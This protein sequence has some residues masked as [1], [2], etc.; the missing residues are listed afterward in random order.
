MLFGGTLDELPDE[1]RAASPLTYVDAVRSPVLITAGAN[2]PRCPPRATDTYV[3]RLRARDHDVEVV[4][5]NRRGHATRIASDAARRGVDIVVGGSVGH[6]SAFMAQ[7]R[8][9]FPDDPDAA[10]Q[11]SVPADASTAA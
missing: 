6:M 8:R 5:T 9:L 10:F 3:E 11:R 2:D 4:E 1:Y 7:A